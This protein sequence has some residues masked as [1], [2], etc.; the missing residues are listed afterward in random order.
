VIK[1]NK[2]AFKSNEKN[3][4]KKIRDLATCPNTLQEE[5]ETAN[6]DFLLTSVTY[7]TTL[8]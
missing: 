8:V 3:C 5:E 4:G 1:Y 7:I 2:T 6:T